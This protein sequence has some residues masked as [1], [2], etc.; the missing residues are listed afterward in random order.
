M[1]VRLLSRQYSQQKLKVRWGNIKFYSAEFGLSNG[2]QQGGVLSPILFSIYL[3][4]L[5][6]DL[7]QS[8]IG[9]SIGGEY[10]GVFAYADDNVLAP[11]PSRLRM[12][13]H[14]CED[15]ADCHGFSFNPSKTQLIQ[16]HWY[17]HLQA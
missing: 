14:K 2:V 13:L 7:K 3:D 9:C 17:S 6:T 11:S 16:F 10:Y 4:E 8:K 5:L 1:V 15:I 12:M